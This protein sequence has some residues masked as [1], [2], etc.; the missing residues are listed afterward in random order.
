M[1]NLK[2]S[3]KTLMDEFMITR[4]YSAED[5]TVAV[6]AAEDLLLSVVNTI[7]DVDWIIR[8]E[9]FTKSNEYHTLIGESLITSLSPWI[10]RNAGKMLVV[11]TTKDGDFEVT[12]V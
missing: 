9:Q 10:V 4:G 12:A 11:V 7:I 6:Y 8:L 5:V 2:Y 3:R 1:N